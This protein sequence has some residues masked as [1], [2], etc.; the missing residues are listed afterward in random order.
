MVLVAPN[1]ASLLDRVQAKAT[2]RCLRNTI[3]LKQYEIDAPVEPDYGSVSL[4]GTRSSISI[5]S[6][7]R[8]QRAWPTRR[9]DDSDVGQKPLLA[10]RK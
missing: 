5:V 2:A 10:V 4:D 3:T 1:A 7:P 9:T 6:R 8:S